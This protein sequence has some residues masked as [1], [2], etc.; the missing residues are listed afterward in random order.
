MYMGDS[1]SYRDNL[2]V[3]AT[4]LCY[5]WTRYRVA[6]RDI[7]SCQRYIVFA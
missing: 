3:R 6:L 1:L 7:V 2:L 5:F 4:V